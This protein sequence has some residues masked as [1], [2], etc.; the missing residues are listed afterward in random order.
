MYHFFSIVVLFL[1]IY[2]FLPQL[3]TIVNRLFVSSVFLWRT[4]NV[5]MR[6][7]YVT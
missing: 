1:F 4:G 2:F 5:V 6:G 7:K 3:G